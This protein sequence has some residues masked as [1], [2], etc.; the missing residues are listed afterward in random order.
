M[1]T[2][3][4][5][6][7]SRTPADLNEEESLT[8]PADEETE[9]PGDLD[10]E[11]AKASVERAAPR[12]AVLHEAIRLEGEYE[13][14]RSHAA[15]FWS[16]IAAGLSMGTS[17][18]AQGLLEHSL[19]DAK[20]VPLIASFGYAMGFV[21]V[22]LGRQQLFTENTLTPVL[23]VLEAPGREKL[24]S[25]LQ[26]WG[27]VLVAN[28]IGGVLFAGA[29]AKTGVFTPEVRDA[30]DA[31]ALRAAAPSIWLQFARGVFAGWLIALMVWL[32]PFSETSR[33]HTIVLMTWLIALGG[34]SHVIVGSIEVFYGCWRG[35]V[36]WQDYVLRFFWP[37]LLGNVLGGIAIVAALNHGQVYSGVHND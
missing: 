7:P 4:E 33:I 26:L 24:R 16:A 11:E 31:I 12:A 19:G 9:T 5:E 13:L 27:I 28:L 14:Q 32:L 2:K 8:G 20:W 34:F 23:A 1:Q 6:D 25:M 36:D 35:L 37:V 22:I 21:I 18:I 17:F 3:D 29:V 15:L 10:E 30:F